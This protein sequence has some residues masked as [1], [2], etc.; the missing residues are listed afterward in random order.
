MLNMVSIRQGVRFRACGVACPDAYC[1]Q[2]SR[3]VQQQN[4]RLRDMRELRTSVPALEDAVDVVVEASEVVL[5]EFREELLEKWMVRFGRRIAEELAPASRELGEEHRERAGRRQAREARR[6]AEGWFSLPLDGVGG[7]DAAEV[8]EFLAES[9]E[10]FVTWDSI[11][12]CWLQ[13]AAGG[14][15]RTDSEWRSR[16]GCDG[17]K[18]PDGQVEPWLVC[19]EAWLRASAVGREAHRPREW[20]FGG[21]E[22]PRLAARSWLWCARFL[23]A[24]AAQAWCTEPADWE[25][26]VPVETA[27]AWWLAERWLAGERDWPV[28]RCRLGSWRW[29]PGAGESLPEAPDL[30]QPEEA[31]TA[32]MCEGVQLFL[33]DLAAVDC[34]ERA[35][36]WRGVVGSPDGAWMAAL[37]SW[38]RRADSGDL[39][40]ALRRTVFLCEVD[41]SAGARLGL[42][43]LAAEAAERFGVGESGID[44]GPEAVP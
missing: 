7:P 33:A 18:A 3:R 32:E 38:A 39:V 27:A 21:M 24:E 10:A 34:V 8:Q 40:S 42:R 19:M 37:V 43:V 15:S 1:G 17:G 44:P 31:T 35:F 29:W 41:D 26:G 36:A 22:D 23:A 25:R 16:V 4:E 6:M 9:P 20:P 11:G 2:Y 5:P 12:R 30:S 28:L 14:K 13:G